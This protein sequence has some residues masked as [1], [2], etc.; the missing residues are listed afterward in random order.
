MKETKSEHQKHLLRSF[1][2]QAM[3][4]EGILGKEA[5]QRKPYY[6]TLAQPSSIKPGI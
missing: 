6:M 4:K 5:F 3:E 1:T 2:Y